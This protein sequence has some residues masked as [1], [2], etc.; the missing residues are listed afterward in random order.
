MPSG[1]QFETLLFTLLLQNNSGRKNK[2]VIW[3]FQFSHS[4]VSNSLQPHELQHARQKDN[5]WVFWYILRTYFFFFFL[6]KLTWRISMFLLLRNNSSKTVHILGEA[7]DILHQSMRKEVL[8]W[9]AV[10]PIGC[11]LCTRHHDLPFTHMIAL[12][13]IFS[14][15]PVVFLSGSSKEK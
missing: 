3:L 8:V 9:W 13:C 7:E 5:S 6:I 10:E 2:R 15:V 1:Q 12:H 14:T 4:V 11:L